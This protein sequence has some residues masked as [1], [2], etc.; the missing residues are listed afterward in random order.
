MNGEG[1]EARG[2]MDIE[3][4]PNSLYGLISGSDSNP[5]EAI[6]KGSEP[7]TQNNLVNVMIQCQAATVPMQIS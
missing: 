4:K 7:A 5:N 6:D 2:T 3:M 1:D